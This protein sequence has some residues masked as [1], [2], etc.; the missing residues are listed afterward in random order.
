L[1]KKAIELKSRELCALYYPSA[2]PSHALL[3]QTA[4]YFDDVF[5]IHPGGALTNPSP[6]MRYGIHQYEQKF[7][8]RLS[9]FDQAVLPL[10]EASLLHCVPPQ[11]HQHLEFIRLITSDLDDPTF[12]ALASETDQ[13]PVFVAATKMEAL[14]PLLGEVEDT[15]SIR[16][17]LH[18][19]VWL[20]HD[21]HNGSA[22]L[23]L[24]HGKYGVRKVAPVL[25]ASI[26]LN[27]AFL[28][29]ERYSLIPV[30]DDPVMARLFQRKI[31]RI[32]AQ[33]EFIDF[34]RELQ[35][36]AASLAIRA[37]EEYLPCFQFDSFEHVLDARQRLAEPLLLFRHAM[38]SL[39]AEVDE[40][41][42]DQSFQK[43][44]ENI[45]NAK[46]RPAVETLK[47]EIERSRDSFV[48]RFLRNVQAGTVP[49][50]GLVL[51]GLPPSA[52]IALG[53]GVL[54]VQAAIETYHDI[55]AVKRNGFSLLLGEACR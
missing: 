29:A 32:S 31:A 40:S 14:L 27:H 9:Q 38:L 2:T 37:I 48:V 24:G 34:Q 45:V 19:R 49:V 35:I 18:R 7:L 42:Y 46:I 16:R 12:V 20:D 47:R 1:H 11:M 13:E 26:L 55:K 21:D 6:S 30:T 41:P 54:T 50:V 5:V 25:A 39:A 33:K 44:I 4:L 51:A 8:D 10:K 23:F 52:V 3:F 22:E 36:K 43:R 15:D 53:A 17:S 28:T